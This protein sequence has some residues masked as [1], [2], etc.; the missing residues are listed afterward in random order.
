M[1]KKTNQPA[2]PVAGPKVRT[3][4]EVSALIE[5]DKA[6][7]IANCTQEVQAVL[8]K[9]RCGLNVAMTITQNGNRPQVD[10]VTT[11]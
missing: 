7:R 8:A 5:E 9:Y 11:D 1:S 3:A 6:L 4:E 2:S 10:I